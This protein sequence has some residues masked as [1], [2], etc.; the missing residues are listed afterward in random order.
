MQTQANSRLGGIKTWR[1]SF[2]LDHLQHYLTETHIWGTAA[3][4]FK[5]S[6][7]LEEN[8]ENFRASGW[9]KEIFLKSD[10]CLSNVC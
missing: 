9:I 3:Q 8:V 1:D 4:V 2:A 5:T 6:L 10:L 7:S